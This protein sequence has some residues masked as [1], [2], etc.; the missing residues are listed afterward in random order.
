MVIDVFSKY[1]WVAPLKRKT[2]K[3]V[4]AAFESILRRYGGRHPRRLQTD[5]GKNLYNTTFAKMLDHYGIRHFATQG[6]A[7]ASVVERFNRTLKGRMYQYFMAQD[8][9]SVLPTLVEG[10]NKSQHRSIG[11]VPKHVTE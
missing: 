5:K 11:M 4:T 8:Y 10:Y 3:A 7:K 1:T 2:G 6:D 9:M